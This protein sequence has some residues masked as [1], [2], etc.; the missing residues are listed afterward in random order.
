MFDGLRAELDAL[1]LTPFDVQLPDEQV[2]VAP[3]EGALRL[4]ADTAD[5]FV[6][7]T[8]DYGVGYPLGRAETEPEARALLL[9]YVGR[10]LPAVQPLSRADLDQLV[11]RVYVTG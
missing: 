10:P 9:A 4:R 1:G 6:L 2:P 11:G 3:L 8:V 5:G 7:E